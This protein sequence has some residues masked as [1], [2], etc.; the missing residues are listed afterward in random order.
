MGTGLSA[1]DP[2][3]T[4]PVRFRRR[5]TIAFIATAGLS[6]GALALGAALTVQATRTAAFEERARQQVRQD[7]RLLA[8]GAP[9]PVVA[10]RLADVEVPGGPGVLVVAE[11]GVVSSVESLSLA[12]V[13]ASVRAA[14]AAEPDEITDSTAR[15]T[16]GS[17]MILGAHDADADVEL[18]LFF[19]RD[20]LVEGLR[21]LRVTLG[22]GWIAVVAGAGVAGSLMAR[23]TL[24]PVRGAADAARKVAEGLL[25]TRLPVRSNDEFG[26]WA[27]SFNRMVAG[28]EDKIGALAAARDRER[29]LSADVAHELRTPVAAVLN[30][31]S[32]L[33]DRRDELPADL[34][35]AATIVG[36]AARRLDRLTAELLE[37]HGLEARTNELLV[38]PVDVG[39]AVAATVRAHG[40]GEVVEVVGAQGIV[41]D[42][43]RRRLE[44]ILVNLI[45][46]A[47]DHGGG[48][49]RVRV[50]G[51]GSGAG[52]T[53]ADDGP[54]IGPADL[55]HIFDRHFKGDSH[56]SA[57][58]RSSG[59]SGLGL[60][61]AHES[62]QLL[63]GGIEVTSELGQGACF[64]VSLP[65]APPG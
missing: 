31:A 28:L 57:Q 24:R 7:L 3:A 53:V 35:D 18:Y 44:R 60:S 37:L 21:A 26:E 50:A 14:V 10:A 17:V 6:A 52:I 36:T 43:D 4:F 64:V 32:H 34:G 29:R 20:E 61:I 58:S 15:T 30:A 23:R 38:E 46:N 55:P 22:V 8:A 1:V 41:I 45:V 25:E 40:W 42:T 49:A 16:D 63:G 27:M 62:A 39:A 59:G 5:L 12:D 11:D 51:H 2:A 54:G 33:A 19:P 65:P 9:A 56:R 48:A 47:L 13:P